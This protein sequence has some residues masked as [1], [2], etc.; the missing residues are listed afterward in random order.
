[1][2]RVEFMGQLERLLVDL[3]ESDRLDAIAYYND[4]FDEAGPENE[5]T[6]IQELGSPGKVAAII[7]ADLNA[8]GNERA[9]YTEQGY[10]DGR[11][12]VNLNT[13]TRR[14]TGYREPKQKRKVPLALLIVLL[15]F[16]SPLIFGAGGGLLGGILGVLGALFGIVVA[17]IA[18]GASFL[19]SGVVCFVYG[20][21]RLAFSPIEGLATM[22]VGGLMLA[23]G[24]ILTVLIAWIAFK[25]LPALFRGIVNLVQKLFHKHT[26]RSKT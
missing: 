24:L 4:Y 25:W 17:V 3:P 16:A 15:I 6:V 23:L 14:E 1:M 12:S 2:N 18:C 22:G 19:V 21:F 13:P 7:K 26:E 10:T 5:A 20:I 9:E 11:D 8:S